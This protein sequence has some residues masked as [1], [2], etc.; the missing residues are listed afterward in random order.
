M[1]R[2]L[3]ACL[4]VTLLVLLLSGCATAPKHPTLKNAQLPDLIPLRHL[5]IN[6]ETSFNYRVSPDGRK[7]GWI[8]VKGRRL[9]VH[10][11][12]V[13]GDKV[14]ALSPAVPGS[15]YS[16]VWTPDSR[17]IL[18]RQDQSGNENY[19]I[20]LADS[21][22][23][24]LPAVDLTPF[25]NTRARIYHIVRTDPDNILITHNERD[26]TVFDLYRVNL[27]TYKQTMVAQNPGDV[28]AWLTDDDGNLRGKTPWYKRQ[29]HIKHL[30]CQGSKGWFTQQAK[31]Y[32]AALEEVKD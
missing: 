25:E 21:G 18:Y 12:Q 8:A 13:G 27:K 29:A 15:I 22:H 28:L 2:S 3:Y 6:K 32:R 19:H 20:Y 24:D 23:T 26:K 4:F 16:F 14:T 5:V 17:R 30:Y 9:T 11:K 7:L 31:V 10:L 1:K